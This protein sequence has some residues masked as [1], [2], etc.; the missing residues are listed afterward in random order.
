[1]KSALVSRTPIQSLEEVYNIVWQEEDFKA[2]VRNNDE[3]ME[4]TAYAAQA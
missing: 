2:P 3:S 4:V 1:M